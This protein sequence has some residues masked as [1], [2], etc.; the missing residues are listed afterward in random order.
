MS[1]PFELP[2]SF[3]FPDTINIRYVFLLLEF[4]T[5]NSVLGIK[6]ACVRVGHCFVEF[7]SLC[8]TLEY[9]RYPERVETDIPD[10]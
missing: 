5:V 6:F 9:F 2:I 1:S 4:W 3:S 7:L 10:N 8:G